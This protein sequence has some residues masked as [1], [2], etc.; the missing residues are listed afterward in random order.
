MRQPHIA[1]VNLLK[2]IFWSIAVQFT[3]LPSYRNET[4]AY[5]I[6]LCNFRAMRSEWGQHYQQHTRS[7]RRQKWCDRCMQSVYWTGR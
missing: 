5:C 4:L 7:S 1:R 6:L 3:H 2:E